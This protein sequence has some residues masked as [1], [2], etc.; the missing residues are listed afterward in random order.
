M[1]P[2]APKVYL[3]SSG[4][5]RV[6]YLKMFMKE[7]SPAAPVVCLAHCPGAQGD[8]A[9]LG[10]TVRLAT[11]MARPQVNNLASDAAEKSNNLLISEEMAPHLLI[12]YYYIKPWLKHKHRCRYRD[13]VMD[14]GAFS[15]HS[16]GKTI[17]LTEY[18]AACHSLAASDPTLTEIFALDVINDHV[19]TRA[20]LIT[21]WENGVPAIPC[22]HFGSPMSELMEM[23]ATY[24]KIAIGGCVGRPKKQKMKFAEQVFARVWPK[25]IHGF[26]FGSEDHIL[27]LP[28]HSTDATNWESGPC[29]FGRWSKFGNLSV[30]GSGHDLRGEIKHFYDIQQRARIRWKKEME[31]L[32]YTP[33]LV[34]RRQEAAA[35]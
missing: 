13:W 35:I 10:P 25:P 8:N 5:G 32:N 11:N 23:A 27:G 26:G 22:F 29:C 20:N 31:Q 9:L 19:A 4:F 24:P 17:D 30:R 34:R 28:F 21:M 2:I 14:S 1:P 18:I 33:C 15:A 6:R 3:A 12:S 7:E 16:S